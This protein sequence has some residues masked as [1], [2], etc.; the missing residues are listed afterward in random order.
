MAY[1]DVKNSRKYSIRI[2]FVVQK[3]VSNNTG[4]PPGKFLYPNHEISRV[5]KETTSTTDGMREIIIFSSRRELAQFY[6]IFVSD[7][8]NSIFV[9]IVKTHNDAGWIFPR[10]RFSGAY[11]NVIL[12]TTE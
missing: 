5:K 8:S 12:V 9:L 6:F 7:A 4:K 11:K 3:V 2:L 10:E 1:V